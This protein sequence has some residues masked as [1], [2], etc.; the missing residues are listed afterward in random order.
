MGATLEKI[1]KIVTEK[2]GY[3]GRMHLAEKTGIPRTKA[4]EMDDTPEVINRVK[5]VADEIVGKDIDQ[6][7]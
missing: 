7:M 6:F 4:A 5:A 2:A 3:D 1:F